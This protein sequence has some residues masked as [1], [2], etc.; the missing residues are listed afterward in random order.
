MQ[1]EGLASFSVFAQ[2]FVETETF[3]ALEKLRLKPRQPGPHG[4][5]RTGQEQRL[6]PVA[7][8]LRFDGRPGP[9]RFRSAR[10]GFRRLGLWF[11]LERRLRFGLG[12]SDLDAAR[13]WPGCR[14]ALSLRP[15]RLGPSGRSSLLCSLCALCHESLLPPQSFPRRSSNRAPPWRARVTGKSAPSDHSPR[16]RRRLR[17]R[18]RNLHASLRRAHQAWQNSRPHAERR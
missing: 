1:H 13:F 2:P 6:A 17:G 10:S 11:R 7:P 15:R 8:S 4:E 3:P 18:G 12:L 16:S 9:S 5:I 14:F